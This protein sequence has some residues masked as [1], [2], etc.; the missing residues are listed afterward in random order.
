MIYE[1]F[2]FSFIFILIFLLTLFVSMYSYS[3]SGRTGPSGCHMDYQRAEYHCHQKKYYNTFETYYYIH[4]QG[5][6]Y[7]PY[8]SYSTCTNAARGAGI[9]GYYCST[10]RY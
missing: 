5:Q 9:W 4:Y 10:S 1:K 3:H 7:G 8:S 2:I 6:V